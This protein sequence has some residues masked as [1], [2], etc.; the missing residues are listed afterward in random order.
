M[1]TIRLSTRKLVVGALYLSSAIL[2]V[3]NLSIYGHTFSVIDLVL[4][5]AGTIPWGIA[6]VQSF[7]NKVQARRIDILRERNRPQDIE[8]V[9]KITN[10][11]RRSTHN[12]VNAALH[13][14][15]SSLY[16]ASD[17]R[18]VSEASPQQMARIAGT[19]LWLCSAIKYGILAF[20]HERLL[21]EHPDR[22]VNPCGLSLAASYL[23]CDLEYLVAGFL[24]AS[25]IYSSETLAPLKVAGNACWLFANAHEVIRQSKDIL[26]A[27]LK[28][29][30]AT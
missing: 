13:V 5:I 22:T 7:Y 18:T 10:G 1:A 28:A 3:I 24:Y 14:C 15:A 2:S 26:C 27:P 20:K 25:A 11:Y 8:A 30:A 12:T 16:L 17:L 21:E 4:T 29:P 9:Q 6:S 19:S 23:Y